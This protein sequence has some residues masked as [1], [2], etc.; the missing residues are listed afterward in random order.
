MSRPTNSICQNLT[1]HSTK[2]ITTRKRDPQVDNLPRPSYVFENLFWMEEKDTAQG[3]YRHGFNPLR[4]SKSS[5]NGRGCR[6][7]R[8]NAPSQAA[9]PNTRR[10]GKFTLPSG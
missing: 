3:S 7:H 5:E 9:A 6:T 4:G 8:S 2:T 1:V 10:P